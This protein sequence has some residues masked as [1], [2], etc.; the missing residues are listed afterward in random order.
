M[1]LIF[2]YGPPG[3]GK[4]TVASMLSASTGLKLFHN[5]LTVNC[6]LS[7]FDFNS[8]S[9]VRLVDKIRLD[10]FEEAAR[11]GIPGIIFT[12]VYGGLQENK[13]IDS[14]ERIVEGSDGEVLYVR[15]YCTE[16]ELERRVGLDSRKI[17]GKL[18][19]RDILRDLLSKYDLLSEIPGRESLSIDNTELMPAEVVERIIA[20]YGLKAA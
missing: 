16:A 1:K 9:F 19:N 15:L 5:Q 17:Y 2:I 8:T 20:H 3:V 6:V 10:I 14:V 4:L 11:E 12:F 18:V 13:F 7:V